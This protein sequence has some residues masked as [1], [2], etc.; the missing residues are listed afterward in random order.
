MSPASRSDILH[1][2]LIDDDPGGVG[3]VEEQ[4]QDFR[5]DGIVE[6]DF[7]VLALFRPPLNMASK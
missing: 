3:I 1:F 4:L 6:V 2:L 5:V 7:T